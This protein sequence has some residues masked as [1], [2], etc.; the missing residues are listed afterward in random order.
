[1]GTP[2]DCAPNQRGQIGRRQRAE[3]GDAIAI[4]QNRRD[5]HG[6]VGERR[7]ER[8]PAGDDG[9]AAVNFTERGALGDCVLCIAVA[10]FGQIAAP[11]GREQPADER[12]C[13]FAGH[14]AMSVPLNPP[15][16]TVA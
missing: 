7:E 4:D 13:V 12:Q 3:H 2:S 1:M 16:A 9:V 15:L 8:P 5:V 6:N 11:R 10:H 14:G